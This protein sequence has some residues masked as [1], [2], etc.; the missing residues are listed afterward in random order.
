MFRSMRPFSL[1]LLALVPGLAQAQLLPAPATPQPISS[2]DPAP[3][4]DDPLP[5]DSPI[6]IGEPVRHQS[7]PVRPAAPSSKPAKATVPAV[8]TGTIEG[9][10]IARLN[11]AQ[12]LY[13]LRTV[14]SPQLKVPFRTVID[15][16]QYTFR[17]DELGAE[18]PLRSLLARARRGE[19]VSLRL[20]VN[21]AK[22]EAALRELDG[23]IRQDFGTLGLNIKAS[24]DRIEAALEATPPKQREILSV[25]PVREAAPEPTQTPEP[26]ATTSPQVGKGDFPYLLASFSTRYDASLR[27]RT[28][29]L[30]MAASHINGTIVPAGAIFSTNSAIGPRNAASGWREAKMFVSGRVVAGTGAGICQAASTL[31]NCALLGNFLIVERHAHSMRVTYVPPSR[32]AA[33]MWGSKDFKFRNTTGAPIRVQTF[34][35]GGKFNAR[36]WGQKV[37]TTPQIELVSLVTSRSG[38]THSQAYKLVGGKKVKLSSDFYRPHP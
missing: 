34:V 20:S 29:N 3:I 36:V 10:S 22:L 38:G 7:A 18:L 24:A 5:N 14:L 1:L 2:D 19:N 33:L 21:R 37:R 8:V 13:K 25:I 6:V 26:Q 30:R 35:S 17:R 27:G 15:S 4:L 32:D 11:D 9:I 31:Y 28:V 16:Y 12:A 23:Q